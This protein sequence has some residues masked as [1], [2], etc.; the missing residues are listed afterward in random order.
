MAEPATGA[1]G[2]DRRPSPPEP[3]PPAPWTRRRRWELL[4]FLELAGLCGLAITQP[5]LDLI[6]RSPDF[7]LMERVDT[8]DV[9]LLAAA[10]ALVPPL[11]LWLAGAAGGLAG[12][13][14]RR[15][16][17]VAVVGG[18]LAAL[19]LQ[20]GKQLSPVRGLPLAAAAVLCGLVGT[21][22]Y[23]RIR[24]LGKVL[25]V[26]SVGP[27]L[28][29]AL[30]LFVSPASALVLPQ[31]TPAPQAGPATGAAKRPPIVVFALDELPLASLL[32]T[33][34]HID[35]WNFPNLAWLAGRSTWYRDAT[36]TTQWT[37]DAFPSMLTGRWPSRPLAAHYRNYPYNLF[38]LL[39]ESYQLN[40]HES[41]TRLCPPRDCG[42]ADAA[43]SSAADEGGGG[44]AGALGRSGE[45]LGELV[46]P[47]DRRQEPSA[48]IEQ[49]AAEATTDAA[50]RQVSRP[51]GFPEFLDGLRP[52]DTPTLH[53][54]HLVLP[55]RPWRWLPDGLRYP[56][57]PGTLGVPRAGALWQDEPTWIELGRRRHWL[58]LA[59]A[60]R[61]LGE[62]LATLRDR[63]LLDQALVVVTADHG[64]SFAPGTAARI[65][66]HGNDPWIMWVP[67]FIKEPGQT[68]GRVDDRNWEH[69]DL[70]PTLAD[71]AGVRLP[72]PVDGRSALR[73]GPRTETAKH[74]VVVREQGT[75]RR[76]TVDGPPNLA[77]V[78]KG[79][80]L[81]PHPEVRPEIGAPSGRGLDRLGP[82]ADL[83][84]RSLADLEVTDGGPPVA[85]EDLAALAKVRPD[86][87]QVPAYV[88]GTVPA[89]VAPGTLLALAVNGRVG[90]VARV[91]PEG[92]AG[93]LRFAGMLPGAEFT[94]GANRLEVLAVEGPGLRRLP[95]RGG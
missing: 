8:T 32:D 63:G 25:R 15:I 81:P 11:V 29:A 71:Y 55:H 35:A 88:R 84:G 18:L 13:R 41:A 19:A 75:A 40:V 3:G 77:A 59:F 49:P 58:Q 93:T 68:R 31:H 48:D 5:L 27:L 56:S 69:V 89:G 4:A 30:F 76:L 1:D 61:L 85:V 54:I 91:A 46:S 39:G 52:S 64:I 17:H 60:D 44:L 14:W 22:L 92:T 21:L 67:L 9:V 72:W 53:Y 70:L 66:G 16:L 28:S 94:A 24:V 95:V 2:E 45:L 6:G 47:S 74:F 90:T 34:G 37:R 65:L 79:G 80:R 57:P 42:G 73:G 7:L 33:Q 20:V 43:T 23:L 78:L 62:T 26:A 87:G 50:G 83:V 82:R 38:S 10:I 36:G 51:A 86:R 12:G